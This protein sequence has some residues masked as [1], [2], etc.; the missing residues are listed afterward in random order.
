MILDKIIELEL[1]Y[2]R[3]NKIPTRVLINITNFNLLVKEL[4]ET[5][6]VETIH[7]M[8]IEIVQSNQLVVI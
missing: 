2:L 7:N 1:E 8:K 3:K 6:Y 5:R 4:E